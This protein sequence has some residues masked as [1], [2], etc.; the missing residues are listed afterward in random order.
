MPFSL[1]TSQSDKILKIVQESSGGPLMLKMPS[2]AA[3]AVRNQRKKT[4][5]SSQSPQAPKTSHHH[6]STTSLSVV[7]AA[8]DGL[9]IAS[10]AFQP[11][12]QTASQGGQMQPILGGGEVKNHLFAWRAIV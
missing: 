10:G 1:S 4:I 12:P 5:S 8:T 7:G 6:R 11:P 2:M 9:K 3:V